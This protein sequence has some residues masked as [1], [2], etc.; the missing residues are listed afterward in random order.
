MAHTPSRNRRCR[1]REENRDSAERTVITDR[2]DCCTPPNQT[3]DELYSGIIPEILM[4]PCC[5]TRRG[6]ADFDA[7]NRCGFWP[8]FAHPRWLDCEKLYRHN[9]T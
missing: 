6:C 8:S 3:W 2:R 5:D 4:L 9:Q 7:A 1:R